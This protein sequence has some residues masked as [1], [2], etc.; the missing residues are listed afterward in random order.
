MTFVFVAN[1]MYGLIIDNLAYEPKII[2][3]RIQQIY[4]YSISYIMVWMA[5][6]KVFE[7]RFDTYTYEALYDNLS[8]ML[9]KILERIPII[10]YVWH[11]SNTMGDSSILHRVFFVLVFAWGHSNS[12]F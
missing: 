1:E 5:K 4:W 7:M 3:R 12:V 11:F 10:F 2:I 9:C 8:D 6:K